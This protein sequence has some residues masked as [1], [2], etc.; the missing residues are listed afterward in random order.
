MARRSSSM[1]GGEGCWAG[2]QA[3]G[4]VLLDVSFKVSEDDEQVG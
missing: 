3:R 1:L 4:E 2:Q